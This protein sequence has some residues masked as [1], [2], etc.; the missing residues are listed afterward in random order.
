MTQGRQC[1]LDVLRA[2]LCDSRRLDF[3]LQRSQISMI[4]DA[5]AV[6]FDAW[7]LI[8]EAGGA[9]WTI[10]GR[11]VIFNKKIIVRL[12]PLPGC[13]NTFVESREVAVFVSVLVSGFL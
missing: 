12:T 4:F 6:I 8:L 3:Y 11:I 1:D 10:S 13:K 9:I 5:R 7:T 2:W